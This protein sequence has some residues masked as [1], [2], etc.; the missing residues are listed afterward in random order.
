[1]VKQRRYI[2]GFV[3]ISGLL[4]PGYAFAQLQTADPDYSDL[5]E[6]HQRDQEKRD[7]EFWEPLFESVVSEAD[8]T[9]PS[10]SAA[11][12]HASAEPHYASHSAVFLPDEDGR[13]GLLLLPQDHEFV[14]QVRAR[15]CETSGLETAHLEP[16][17]SALTSRASS[18][19]LRG[20]PS[21]CK[22]LGFSFGAAG[23]EDTQDFE[24]YLS[25]AVGDCTDGSCKMRG[26]KGEIRLGEFKELEEDKNGW[27]M[28]AAADGTRVVWDER[29]DSLRNLKEAVDVSDSFTM[30][31]VEAGVMLS[32]GRADVSLNYVHRRSK[33]QTWTEKVVDNAD[34]VGVKVTFD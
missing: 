4:C 30:G 21:A 34:Y 20:A 18:F 31:D 32:R 1:M 12:L 26:V 17:G 25:P 29:P 19:A 33:F 5:I 14:E 10:A 8:N 28:Y 6:A 2:S 15:G 27:Y 22:G 3:A 13:G 11:A 16:N 7:E 23:D 24:L 9:A